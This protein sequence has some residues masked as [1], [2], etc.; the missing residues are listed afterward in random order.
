MVLWIVYGLIG[1]RDPGRGVAD[2]L[3]LVRRL[4]VHGSVPE[5]IGEEGF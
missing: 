5:G 2:V 4:A 3:I 1:I